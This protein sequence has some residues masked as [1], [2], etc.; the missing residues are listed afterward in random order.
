MGIF[1]ACD[2]RGIADTELADAAAE[3]L[4]RAVGYKLK[5]KCVL[6]GG[7]VRL[8]TQR[9]KAIFIRVLA[10]SGCEVM[11]IGT[12]AT[13]VFYYALKHLKVADGIM[14]TASHNPAHYNGFKLILGGQPVTESIIAELEA[15]YT[16][17]VC[18]EAPGSSRKVFISDGYL[19][20]MADKAPKGSLK[21]V[22]D[23]GNGAASRFAPALYRALG[24][25]VV[26]LFC[27][28][29]GRFLNRPPNP[30][31]ARNL[32]ALCEKVKETGADLGIA[33]D[34][35]G[36]RAA[37]VDEGGRALENDAVLVL[38]ARH[39]LAE[40]K[41]AVVYDA[42]CSMT[43]AEQIALAGGRPLMARAGHT[44]IRDLFLR[45]NAVFAGEA[46]GH[47]FFRALGYDDGMFA[48]TQ[49][50]ALVEEYGALSVQI[51]RIPV[52]A[53]TPEYRVLYTAD[54]KEAVLGDIAGR[55]QMHP[56][57][58]IDGV[59]VEFS[60]GWGMIRASVTEPLFTLR[61]EA[62]SAARLREIQALLLSAL[63]EQLRRDVEAEIQKNK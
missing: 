57:N 56:V 42:K 52:Y 47:F 44:F 41:G 39:F 21:I 51:G 1:K 24:H 49:V 28:P 48:G 40:E 14:V 62:K 30:A 11:D 15:L 17:G 29:D 2:I 22:L 31:I 7:D 34:G 36:D 54:D 9:L 3:R 20:E 60:D 50:A 19:R 26:E 55:L 35:D 27:E 23:A 37:F 59:R 45:E 10:A 18:V 53:A 63:P 32:M 61:F 4:A 43:V 12:V 5:G 6:L 58:R 25:E 33:F 38:L 13:P 46:S 16:A 8:S